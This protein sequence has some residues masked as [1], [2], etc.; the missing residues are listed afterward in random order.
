MFVLNPFYVYVN[1]RD[2]ESGTD[3]NFTYNIQYPVDQ[4]FT[5][6]VLLNAL[7]PKSYYLI[8]NNTQYDN[9]FQLQENNSIVTITIPLGSYLLSAWKSTIA[10]LLTN[11]SP[12]GLTYTVTYPSSSGSDTGKLTFTQN[13]SS[14]VSSL[15]FNNHL[16][17]PFGFLS[18]STNVFS[19]NTL[20][21]TAVI[22]LQSEDRL[23]LSSSL[24]NNG[25]DSILASI[26]STT[27]INYSSIDYECPDC[28]FNSHLLSSDRQN[29]VSFTLTDENFEL[30]NLNNLNINLSILFYKADD[31]YDK[32]RSFMKMLVLK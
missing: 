1:S 23:L 18:G 22:K 19:G 3:E 27:S 17:E 15:I 8:Q 29:T 32:L 14:I 31:I 30:I 25:R 10:T 5:H 13:N 16:Y 24:V 11:A 21:S 7:I 20:T 6:C 4:E 28:Q 26:N 2:R 9:I 12:N